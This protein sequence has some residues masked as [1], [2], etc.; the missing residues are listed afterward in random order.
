[1]V[2]NCPA[3]HNC[4][5]YGKEIKPESG[6]YKSMLEDCQMR[7]DTEDLLN[8]DISRRVSENVVE[9][10][11]CPSDSRVFEVHDRERQRLEPVTNVTT[12]GLGLVQV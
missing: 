9:I 2:L 4:I 7:S 6:V 12:S 3:K 8:E 5:D 11:G 1:M 10:D